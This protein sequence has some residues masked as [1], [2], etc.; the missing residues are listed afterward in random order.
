MPSTFTATRRVFFADTDAAGVVYFNRHLQFCHEAYELWLGELGINLTALLKK[1]TV[2][3]PLVHAEIDYLAPAYCGDHLTIQLSPQSASE[4]RFLCHYKI[5]K[6]SDTSKSQPAARAVPTEILVA[7]AQTQHV[8][9][10]FS[11]RQPC[12]LPTLIRQQLAQSK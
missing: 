6:L 3:L 11:T 7:K 1:K 5:V 9:I 4:H 8:S 10:A 2:L 12:P